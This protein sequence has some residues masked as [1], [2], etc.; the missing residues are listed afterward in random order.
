MSQTFFTG[1][2]PLIDTLDGGVLL[3]G[4]STSRIPL[5]EFFYGGVSQPD[6]FNGG[7]HLP[8]FLVVPLSETQ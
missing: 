4:I 2:S 8:G 7:I 1:G 3:P 5:P 6:V